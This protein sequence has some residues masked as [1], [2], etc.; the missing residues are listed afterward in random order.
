MKLKT[1][2]SCSTLSNLPKII[3]I[4]P[5]AGIGSRMQANKPKQYLKIHNK[6]I[7]EHTLEQLLNYPHIDTIILA[8]AKNDPYLSTLT[9]LPHSKI[10]VVLGGDSRADS[11]YNAL[12]NVD[13]KA[14]VLVHDAA[15]P[16]IT[17]QDLDKLI[18][19]T[20]PS[21]A[22]LATPVIDTLKR[23]NL[24]QKIV[25]TEDRNQLWHALTPQFFPAKLL[26]QALQQ[27]KN[28]GLEITDDASAIE[29]YG[30]QPLL[31]VGRSDNI[32]ITRPED[33]ALAEFYLTQQHRDKI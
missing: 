14:W 5:A 20:N 31:I 7:L 4:V 17:H 13:E 26:K 18:K 19:I 10:Q 11:V 9:L 15:R 6:T 23:S 27:A 22:I 8:V 21:G 29:Q 30:L 32:K 28:Q 3:A 24:T 25:Q 16:C 1:D 2:F 33:L 12:Q